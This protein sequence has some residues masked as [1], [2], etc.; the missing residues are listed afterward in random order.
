[1]FPFYHWGD[2][3]EKGRSL[4]RISEQQITLLFLHTLRFL[5]LILLLTSFPTGNKI[6]TETDLSS[7]FFSILVHEACQYFF[8]FSPSLGRK[9]IHLA[10]DPSFL[11]DLK[12]DLYDTGFPRGPS[13]WQYTDHVLLCSP[14]QT[15]SQE[16]CLLLLK[17]GAWK[18]HKV[19]KEKL[20][21]WVQYLWHLIW[22]QVLLPDADRLHRVPSLTKPEV[23][24]AR[25]SWA[26]WLLPKSYSQF[27]SPVPISAGFTKR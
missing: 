24:T 16:D 17:P 23:A 15:S 20:Q 18:E 7:A 26:G 11:T 14:F 4:S 21:T 2:P 1:M 22:E 3:R 6:F 8:F 19:T 10:W 13:L 5:S 27:L 9:T 12:A 25:L